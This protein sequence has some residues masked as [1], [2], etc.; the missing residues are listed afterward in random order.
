MDMTFI[1]QRRE[2][3][4][5]IFYD[6]GSD[7]NKPSSGSTAWITRLWV[8][9]DR[10]QHTLYACVLAIKLVVTTCE[11]PYCIWPSDEHVRLISPPPA[12]TW[13][14]ISL[15]RQP[16]MVKLTR[17]IDLSNFLSIASKSP[18][19]SFAFPTAPGILI[20][21][22]NQGSPNIRCR[23]C[24]SNRASVH[25]MYRAWIWSNAVIRGARSLR[26][27]VKAGTPVDLNYKSC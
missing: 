5:V 26:M 7:F 19:M 1:E 2:I 17:K 22:S 25:R 13:Y 21:S 16:I 10:N 8:Y 15:D 11:C 18:A 12:S 4:I 20:I 27:D 23:V 3:R 14:W 24:G 9:L 6:K